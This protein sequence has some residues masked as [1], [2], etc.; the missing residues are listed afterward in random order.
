MKFGMKTQ[1]CKGYLWHCW[2]PPPTFLYSF[3][4]KKERL[5]LDLAFWSRVS[6]NNN[7]FSSSKYLKGERRKSSVFVF[8]RLWKCGK[9]HRKL[10]CLFDLVTLIAA[11]RKIRKSLSVYDV[12]S[13]IIIHWI[14]GWVVCLFFGVD[15]TFWTRK[16]VSDGIVVFSN[17]LVH[18]IFYNWI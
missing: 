15:W 16:N 6:C 17:N 9:F 12:N 1:L 3:W 14:N 7:I 10:S 4:T 2:Y 5:S 13:F 8:V 11:W 18:K